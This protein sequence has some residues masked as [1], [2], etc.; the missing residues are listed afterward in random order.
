MQ[1]IFLHHNGI[2]LDIKGRKTEKPINTWKLKNALLNNQQF[3]E[4]IIR[5]F[6]KYVKTN[7]IENTAYQNLGDTTKTVL[8]AKFLVVNILKI[9]KELKSMT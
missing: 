7:V 8:R 2:K 4:E 9:K 6:R 3:K 5:E 1:S